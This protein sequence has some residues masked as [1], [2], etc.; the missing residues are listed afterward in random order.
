MRELP[1]LSPSPSKGRHAKLNIPKAADLQPSELPPATFLALN[2]GIHIR[3]SALESYDNVSGIVEIAL[4][5]HQS[6]KLTCDIQELTATLRSLRTSLHDSG[7]TQLWPF[8]SVR[9][10]Q[11]GGTERTLRLDCIDAYRPN[12]GDVQIY[13]KS[14]ATIV[15]KSEQLVPITQALAAVY[16]P[17]AQMQRE[18][19]RDVSGCVPFTTADYFPNVPVR[20]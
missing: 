16:G 3:I 19:S 13:M 15:A 20:R 8:V 4:R 9:I 1:F 14:G 7:A 5:G 6:F 11:I 12:N 18:R 17:P 2:N 10:N